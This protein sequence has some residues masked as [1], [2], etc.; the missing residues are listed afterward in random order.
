MTAVETTSVS[1][2]ELQA[3]AWD[4][5]KGEDWKKNIDVRDFIQE[6]YTPYTGDESFLAP[7]TEKTKFLWN[8]LDDNFLAVER[9]QRIYDVDTHTPAGIDAFPAGYIDGKS[10]DETQDNVIVGLQ[11]DVPCKRAMMPNGGWRMVEQALMEAGK[12]PDPEVKK[13]FTRYR[14]THNDGVF[15]VYTRRIK[16]AR[17]NKILTGLPDAYGRGR[18]IGDYRRVALYGINEL[19]A[20]KKAD[21]DSIPYRNDFTEEEIEHWI[22]FREEHSEQIKALKQLLKLGQEYGLD[23]SRPAQNAKEAVQWT[24]MAY[25]ASV[26]SQDGAAMSIGRLSAFFDIYFERDLQSGLIDETDAQEIVDNIVMKLRI[27]RFLRTKD[28]D[29]IFSG[30]P[31]W[32]TWSDAGF[33]DDGRPLVTK[34]SFRLLATLTLEH[35]GPGPEP[36]ITI[37]WDPKLPEGYKRFCARISID[38]SAIQYE[39]DK[40][41]R[42]HWG[43]DAA[44][45]CCVSPMRVGKQMQFFGARVN[46]AKALLYAMNGGRDEMTGM[47]VIDEGVIKPVTPK[48][49]GS[50]DFQEVK[51]NY[52]KALQWL[53]E[54]YVEALNIIH[55][56]HDKYAYESIEMAL[57]DKE[58]YRTLGCGMS[59]LS[60]AADSLAA[61]KYAKVYPIYNKDAEGTPEY[62][63]G[64]ADDLIVNYKT[65]GEFPVYG[66]DDDRADDLAK[67]AVSTVM[68]QIKRLPVYRG[69]VPTQSILTI[70]SN[71]EYGKNT[72][73]FPSGH[74]KGT[75]YAP[76]ANPE[77][78]MDSH[79]MLPSMFSVGKIDYD[80][81]LDGISLTNTITPDGLGRDEDERINNLVGI[82]DA[83]NG[84]GLYHA[85]INVLRK[86]QLE[87]AV[88]HP[89]KYPHLTVRVSGYAVNFVKLTRE[90]QLDV[91]SRTFHQGAVT[92]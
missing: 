86:E 73:S 4:S 10:A 33:G 12:E 68:G 7:A 26:K 45:A 17:H 41:I 85:N 87:D 55:Y 71:V 6:N 77:N 79:G 5:F 30:D 27:V 14:K 83:G 74:K 58:V 19:I 21:K 25:L 2:E 67:W 8:Y 9:K 81:A 65:V 1:P 42:A 89:E 54:T 29:N 51:D 62:V 36:N 39:S 35:L 20:H 70:T 23:L 38:T 63:E 92:D 56:M 50:L 43:D 48:E 44:I 47:Q 46:S 34:T 16:L 18:I 24:Y 57:H 15:D 69:A 59:G 66:N 11:T 31:Y 84:H 91:I 13:I 49:D 3:K 72:G 78:G 22:R 90:Q 28:Y 82:L 76:G 37:F 52:E 40:D 53:S 75:P 88:E 64:A 80:D 32:A 60:I 61:I